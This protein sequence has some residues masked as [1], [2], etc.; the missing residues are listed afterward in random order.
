MKKN[1]FQIL[2][3]KTKGSFCLQLPLNRHG[4]AP[5]VRARLDSRKPVELLPHI[6]PGGWT[7]LPISMSTA[8]VLP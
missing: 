5:L 7:H 6:R 1:I 4:P 3:F 8:K 2:G